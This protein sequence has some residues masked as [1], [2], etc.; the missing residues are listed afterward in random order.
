MN[1]HKL[2]MLCQDIIFRSLKF[3]FNLTF[4]AVF[5]QS[6]KNVCSCLKLFDTDFLNFIPIIYID[7]HFEISK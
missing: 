1:S 3:L 2:K 5:G 4:L 6:D 7:E